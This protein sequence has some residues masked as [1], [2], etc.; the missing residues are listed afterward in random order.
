MEPCIAVDIA[1]VPPR[2]IRATLHAALSRRVGRPVGDS[3]I[4]RGEKG[5]PALA[6][7]PGI[8]FNVTHCRDL[9]LVALV[10]GAEVGIDIERSDRA[11]DPDLLARRTL[12]E[13]ERATLAGI[14][15]PDARRRFVLR[16]WVRKE[17]VVKALGHGLTLGLSTVDAGRDTGFERPL[18][19]AEPVAWFLADLDFPEH[20]A[21]VATLGGR[22]SVRIA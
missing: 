1:V 22:P 2:E 21:A 8:G 18:G 17:A 16:L 13:A 12:C 14:V 7:A 4:A 3:D 19:G 5:K 20:V 11:I 10:R 6:G 15:D 9:G